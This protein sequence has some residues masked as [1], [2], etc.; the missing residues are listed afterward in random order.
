VVATDV[1]VPALRHPFGLAERTFS[2]IV[3]IPFPRGG[4][5][6]PEGRKMSIRFDSIP[7]VPERFPVVRLSRLRR[8]RACVSMAHM[9]RAKP[10]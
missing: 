8:G 3:R 9:Q 1:V 7:N 2:S 6:Y 4:E 5:G 10:T